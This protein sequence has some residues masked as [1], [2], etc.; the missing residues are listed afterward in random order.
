ML[1]TVFSFLMVVWMLG[2]RFHFGGMII[3][4]VLVLALIVLMLKL[5]ILRTSFN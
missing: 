4:L 3:P 1:W 5:V 2:L